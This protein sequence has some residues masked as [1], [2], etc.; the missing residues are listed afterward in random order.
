L[1]ETSIF[2]GLMVF[3]AIKR[4]YRMSLT[5]DT[6]HYFCLDSK[7]KPYL[8]GPL[9]AVN[10]KFSR[11]MRDSRSKLELC[12]ALAFAKVGGRGK[13]A[14]ILGRCDYLHTS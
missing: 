2:S 3:E 13:F 12:G 1:I 6:L 7:T 4:S 10:S 5:S 14:K 9:E 11:P 8:I